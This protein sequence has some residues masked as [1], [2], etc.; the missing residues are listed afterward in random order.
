M[1]SFDTAIRT[2][3]GKYAEFN[4]RATRA[5]FW[6]WALFTGLVGIVL[7][8][9][10]VMPV[11]DGGNVGSILHTIWNVAIFLPSLAVAVRR[12]RDAGYAWQHMF[13]CLLPF[14]GIIVLIVFWAQPTKT[15]S[16]KT[17]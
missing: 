3:F 15:G 5:E 9:F 10:N 4:G 16:S 12:L 2:V 1:M 7:N 14:A 11:G 6:W 8:T 13:W 17:A